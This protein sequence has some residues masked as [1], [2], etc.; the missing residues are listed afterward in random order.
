MLAVAWRGEAYFHGR[1]TARL[2]LDKDG[3]DHLY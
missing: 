1:E 3:A 2:E